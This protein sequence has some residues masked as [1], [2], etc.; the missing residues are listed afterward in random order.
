MLRDID[1]KYEDGVLT[2]SKSLA[3]G[4]SLTVGGTSLAQPNV[5]LPVDH[6]VIAWTSHP[7][8]NT[9]NT[10]TVNGKIY[11]TRMPIRAAATVSKVWWC[12]TTGPT[13]PTAGQNFAG[14][15]DSSGTLLSSVNIDSVTGTGPQSATLAAAQNI[16]ANSYVWM[17]LMF[18]AVTPPTLMRGGGLSA[19]A[20]VF[21]QS[22]ASYSWAVN[23]TTTGL[24]A[25]PA[26][27]T[28][29]NNSL[30]SAFACWGALS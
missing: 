15:Y 20:N 18:N 23:G 26:S 1:L 3:V 12:P 19:A 6:G 2:T 17:A 13:T 4:G 29:A 25:L 22:P 30:T 27:I 16:A 5:T 14:L 8:L 7:S 11:L 28:P 24:T 9:S 21:N 10:L